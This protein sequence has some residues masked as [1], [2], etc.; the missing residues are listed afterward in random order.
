[1]QIETSLKYRTEW[2]LQCCVIWKC[3]EYL[4]FAGLKPDKSVTN[5]LDFYSS[6]GL[7]SHKGL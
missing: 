6:Y 2:L 7:Q 5:T 3:N 4:G 1:M